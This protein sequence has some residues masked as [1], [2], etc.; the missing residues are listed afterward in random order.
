MKFEKNL[1]DLKSFAVRILLLALSLVA[2]SEAA[3]PYSLKGYFWPTPN[4]AFLKGE[5]DA[6]VAQPTV[7]GNVESAFFGCVRNHGTRFH[8][9]IDLRPISRDG[10]GEALDSV[11]AFADGV[12]RYVNNDAQKS[13]YGRYI[14][15]EHPQTA[16][17]LVTLYAHLRSVD[18]N[19]RAGVEVSGGTKLARMGRSASYVIPKSRAH[20]H[21]EIAFWLGPD[22][23]DWYDKQP[24]SSK[25]DHGAYNGMNMVGLDVWSF[26]KALR[27]GEVSTVE[28]F[29][30][31]EEIAY[32]VDVPYSTIPDI[33]QVNPQLM[34]NRSLPF[35]N[36]AGWRIDFTWYGLPIGWTAL[37]SEQ[38]KSKVLTIV[39]SNTRFEVQNRCYEMEHGG[40]FSGP[41][42]S[43]KRLIARLFV[44]L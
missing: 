12:V 29:I 17:G 34:K 1:I 23:Q 18:S 13:S 39:E 7:S 24:Y 38:M 2:V 4:S 37:T 25:N 22:F 3:A 11:F 30:A 14:V 20:L 28:E 8:E 40:H 32:V 9:G 5:P 31:S 15:I 19:I 26:W 27:S 41:G 21:F 35:G 6:A 44:N 36:L 43:L 33:L 10:N 16:P 42:S